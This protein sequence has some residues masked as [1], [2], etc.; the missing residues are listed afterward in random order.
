M[1]DCYIKST[2]YGTQTRLF[3]DRSE[4]SDFIRS[5]HYPLSLCS[6]DGTVAYV[7]QGSSFNIVKENDKFYWHYLKDSDS[8]IDK[9]L[10]ASGFDVVT[11]MIERGVLFFDRHIYPII[12]KYGANNLSHGL[13]EQLNS[14][15]DEFPLR[16]SLSGG[17]DSIFLFSLLFNNNIPFECYTYGSTMSWE[18]MVASR[19]CRKYG[20]SCK[21]FKFPSKARLMD[22]Y[23]RFQG[24]VI[25]PSLPDLLVYSENRQYFEGVLVINGQT[26]DWL[27]GLHCPQVEDDY[28]LDNFIRKNFCLIDKRNDLDFFNN[29]L[30]ALEDKFGK[31]TKESHWYYEKSLRQERY[32]LPAYSALPFKVCMPFW[33]PSIITEFVSLTNLQREQTY[34][35]VYNRNVDTKFVAHIRKRAR[36]I[37]KFHALLFWPLRI[38]GKRYSPIRRYVSSYFLKYHSFY[39][40]RTYMRYLLLNRHVRNPI[41][42]L[43][44]CTRE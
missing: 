28:L 1:I 43:A 9:S 31:L 6:D 15:A 38:Y 40:Q 25:L 16:L 17:D 23:K 12:V 4:L 26:G 10:L 44:K 36:L 5:A 39:P 32:I 14:Y 20:V 30:K 33:S 29:A 35:K 34:K 21:H 37:K 18:V 19:L 2:V 11:V 41:Y 8:S 22:I 3:K 42:W 24:S 13:I 27:R 7:S